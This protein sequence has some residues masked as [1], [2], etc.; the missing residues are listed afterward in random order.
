MCGDLSFEVG[1][2]GVDFR[3]RLCIAFGEGRNFRGQLLTDAMHFTV[4][5]SRKS[6]KPFLFDNQAFDIVFCKPIIFDD[7]SRK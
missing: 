1:N 2:L 6:S 5:P 3:K 7:Q 4:E